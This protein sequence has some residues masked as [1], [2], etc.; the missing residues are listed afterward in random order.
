M[1]KPPILHNFSVLLR[2]ITFVVI[3]ISTLL[4]VMIFGTVLAVPI[5]GGDIMKNIAL[6]GTSTDPNIIAMAKYF[7]IVSQFGLFLIPTLFFAFLDGRHIGS[8]LKI[9]VTPNLKTIV[10]AVLAILSLV[11]LI[12]FIGDINQQMSFPSFL[13]DIETWMRDS[14]DSAATM[15][16]TFLNV[17][18]IEGL[19]INVLM[20]AIIPAIGE[21]FLF[22]GI[23]QKLFHQWSK[24]IHFAV[25]FSAFIFSAIHMQ[26]YGFVPRFLLGVLLG[27]AYVW[28]GSLW[29]P[30]SI[31]FVNNFIAVLF[32]YL[33][34]LGI[35]SN[36][37]ETIGTGSS[38]VLPLIASIVFSSGFI[39]L[40][41]SHEKKKRLDKVAVIQ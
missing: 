30:I 32:S 18:T 9:N 23:L 7:Q 41:Y 17:T 10:F 29:V 8:Y 21:E 39:F 22:R 3:I 15:M 11:P 36:F 25:I 35:T 33:A 24:N 19:L 5:F 28:S 37:I 38:G 20:M 4:I 34:G 31:H 12:N 14:E 6:M 1:N 13:K 27:Y 26:F 16:N 40:L 2:I